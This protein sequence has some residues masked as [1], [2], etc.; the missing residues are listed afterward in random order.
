MI[1]FEIYLTKILYY[2]IVKLK[3]MNTKFKILEL[4]AEKEMS[5]SD[6]AKNLKLSKATILYHLETLTKEG[7]VKVSREEKVKNF[8]KKYYTISIPN[9]EVFDTI[10]KSIKGSVEEG[11]NDLFKNL[12]RI[13][14]YTLLKISPPIFKKVGFEVGYAVGMEGYTMEDLADLWEKLKL[15][16]V[17][18]SK[19][20]LTIENCYFCSGLPN[21]GYTYCKFDEGFIAGFLT[22]SLNKNVKVSET[23]CWGL[24]FELCEFKIKICD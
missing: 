23:K 6:L 4:L 21:V 17:S 24:G 9:G 8:I 7:F 14:G 18:C 11:R 2:N 16:N 20:K 5:I 13:L 1:R 10:V 22:K 12:I 19:D 3:W 15:G